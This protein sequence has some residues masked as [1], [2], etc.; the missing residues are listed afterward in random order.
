MPT[1]TFN[2]DEGTSKAQM[3]AEANA[4]AQ[5]EKLVASQEAE[6]QDKYKRVDQENQDISLIGG[7]FKS[8]EDLLKAYEELQRK[9]GSNKPDDE[10]EDE[11][12]T[13]TTENVEETPEQE[14][15]TE[16]VEYMTELG[17]EFDET[18]SLSE[19]AIERLSSMD[20]KDLIASYLQYQAK[21]TQQAKQASLQAEQITDIKASVGG[22]EAYGQMLS[23]AAENL[24]AAEIENFNQVTNTNNPAA[25][26]YAVQVLSQKWKGDVG[27]EA[28]LVSGK[29]ASNKPQVYRSQAELGRDIADPRYHT[30]PAFRQD[31]EDKL[32]RSGDLL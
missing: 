15:T 10:E 1:L 30:D 18:G 2:P 17:K 6:E 32:S 11:E 27:Y 24:D 23:W 9:L 28:P 5:G 29:K 13:E 4:L 31:V 7:K 22:D 25:I 14:E 20:T 21:S 3:E 12:T 8:Q 16:A 19:D 26:G